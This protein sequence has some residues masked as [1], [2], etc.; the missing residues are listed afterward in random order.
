M[1]VSGTDRDTPACAGDG[2][3]AMD[4]F[5]HLFNELV[6][7]ETELWNAV[8]ACLRAEHDLPLHRFEPMQIIER[9]PECRVYDIAETL[10]I[11]TGGASKIVDSIETAGHAKRRPNPDDRRSSIIELTPAGKRL[12]AKATTTFEAE[13]ELRLGSAL[14]DRAMRQFASALTALRAAASGTGASK[15]A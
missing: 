4:D 11:T 2:A 7:F 14:S 6:R 1:D 10:S 15:A 8:D 3:I 12:L 9:T 13:L 5:K